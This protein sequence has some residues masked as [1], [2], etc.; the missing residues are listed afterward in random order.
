MTNLFP[1]RNSWFKDGKQLELTNGRFHLGPVRYS[2]AGIYQC[3]LQNSA[4][5]VTIT[6]NVTVTGEMVD[7]K[8]LHMSYVIS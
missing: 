5:S 7:L 1:D 3:L 2:E 4:G 6:F 8:L